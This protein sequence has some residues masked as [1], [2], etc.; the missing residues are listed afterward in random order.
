MT[1]GRFHRALRRARG[2]GRAEAGAALVEFALVLPIFLL[3]MFGLLDFGRLGYSVVMAETAVGMATRIAVVRP[4]AC[5]TAMTK[6]NTRGS[7]TLSPPA[8]YGTSCSAGTGICAAPADLVCTGDGGSA[9]F[10]EIWDRVGP[11]M[12]YGT[13]KKNLQITYSYDEA[14]GFL[15]GPYVPRV[16]VTLVGN[17][18]TDP[19]QANAKFQFYTPIAGLA[20]I[21]TGQ[22]TTTASEINLPRLTATLPG[23]DLGN[24]GG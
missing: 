1:A 17:D 3:L 21:Y 6:T 2:F 9:V 19:A 13:T 4:S 15:G 8:P 10:D 12:P 14:L 24:G 23:E 16:T 20:N 5:L 7:S 11:L 22:S 18:V